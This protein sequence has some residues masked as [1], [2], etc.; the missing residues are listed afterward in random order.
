MPLDGQIHPSKAAV[1]MAVANGATTITEVQAQVGLSRSVVWR[2]LNTLRDERWVI[3][4]ANT[5][6][7]LRPRFGIVV[8]K[9][10]Q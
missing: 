7:S 1:L 10:M 4:P 3:W 9:W 8:G 6:G 2:W 5:E